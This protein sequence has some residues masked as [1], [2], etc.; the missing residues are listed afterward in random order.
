M[1]SKKTI[2]KYTPSRR[3]FR[4]TR[5]FTLIEVMVVVAIIG[6]LAAIGYPAYTEQM[7]K[8]RRAD[9]AGALAGLAGAL[10]R[11]AIETGGYLGAVRTNVGSS[12]VT[13]VPAI[14]S[15]KSPIDG[16]ERHYDLKISDATRSTFLI[17]AVPSGGQAADP[18]GTLT[19]NQRGDRGLE[20]SQGKSVNDCW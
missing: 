12:T 8:T 4:T 16:S 6:L 15:D 9:A 10:E 18:C 5:G 19:L 20:G 11:H 14:F 2:E 13:D 3:K 17:K 7:R 1:K